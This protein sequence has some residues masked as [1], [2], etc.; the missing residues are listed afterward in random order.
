MKIHILITLFY[1]LYI[2]SNAQTN[3]YIATTGNDAN[4]GLFAT[5]WKTIQYG[6]VHAGIN[7]TLNILSGTYNEKININ[8]SNIYIRNYASNTPLVSATGLTTQDAVFQIINQSNIT[9]SGLEIANNIQL[10]AQ[11]ILVD[12]NCQNITIK[13]CKIHDIHFS[14]NPAASVNSSKNAQGIIVYGSHATIPISNLKILNN[15]LYDCRLGYSEGIAVNG[16]VDG[17]SVI[18]NTVR[19]ITNIGIDVIGHEGTCPTPSNDQARNGI[20]KY[21]KT[22]NCLS[23]YATSGG[24]YVD[25]GKN[26]IIENNN[27]YNNGYGIEIGCENIGKTTD[28]ITVRNN[29]FYNNQVC[30]IA[31]GGYAYPSGSGKV[32][33]CTIKNNTCFKDGYDLN[34]SM[35]ELYLSY[36]ENSIIQNNIFYVS[37]QNFLGYAELGQPSLNF[38]YNLFYSDNTPANLEADWNGTSYSTLATFKSGTNTNANSPIGNP[39]FY[40]DPLAPPDALPD[41][42]LTTG[43]AAIDKGNPGFVAAATE[44]DID[45]ALRVLNIV[46]CGADEFGSSPTYTFIGNGD[47][48]VSDNWMDGFI[49]P[50]YTPVNSIVTID[51]IVSGECILNKEQHI[52]DNAQLIVV[53]GKKLR[54][55]KGLIITN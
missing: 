25:G 44:R 17:F 53:S 26:I 14:S 21:N 33:N 46:D 6:V 9:I 23:P 38:N 43:S 42:H 1:F 24:L 31:M 4:N 37:T 34:A 54:I 49:P 5:P 48:D 3:Y 27:S 15:T 8:R 50:V 52:A 22:Y 51:P 40:I 35:G 20:V 30:A 32:T 16:N 2:P 18:G 28:N 12:G 36:S 45:H 7:D 13:N 55:I 29:I 11:G 39:L 41:F 47:W 19:N 10:D